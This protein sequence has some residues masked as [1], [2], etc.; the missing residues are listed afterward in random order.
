MSPT[1]PALHQ[2]FEISNSVAIYNKG[3]E[4]TLNSNE[5]KMIMASMEK[6][7]SNSHEMPAF[8][9]S[10]DNET[11]SELKNGVWVEF[12]YPS[13]QKYNDMSF[14][15]LLIRVSPDDMGFNII[16]KHDGLYEGRCYYISLELN[17][18]VLYNT[19]LQIIN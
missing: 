6:M 8:G 9:V 11:R 2:Y 18:Q 17:M 12:N 10:L 16:R 7:L 4:Y 15:S 5:R 14:D 13:T 1:L 3:E 19:I